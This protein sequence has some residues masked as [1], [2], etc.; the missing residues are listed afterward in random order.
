MLVVGYPLLS[1]GLCLG[2]GIIAH[3]TLPAQNSLCHMQV[4]C[5]RTERHMELRGT[6]ADTH[7]Q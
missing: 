6:W 5:T 3:Q 7:A 4:M 2:T 1:S